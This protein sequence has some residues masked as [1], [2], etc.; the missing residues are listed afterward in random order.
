LSLNFVGPKWCPSGVANQATTECFPS[1]VTAASLQCMIL[2]PPEILEPT[3]CQRRIAGRILDI[4]VPEVGL[5]RPCIDPVV[6]QLKAAGVAEH[7]GVHLDAQVGDDPS[8]LDHTVEA[9]RR[10]WSPALGY[11]DKARG[12]RAVA[13]V[14]AEFPQFPAQH[15]GLLNPH[16]FA[17]TIRVCG[18]FVPD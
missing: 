9:F 6:R 4:A 1:S 10:Q 18:S 7:M 5:Q 17:R 11:K 16:L 8:A 13:L 3:R 12:W 2:I 14:F 15:R